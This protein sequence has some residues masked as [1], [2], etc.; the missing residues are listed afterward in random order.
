ML[1]SPM[2]DLNRAIVEMLRHDGRM[3]FINIAKRLEV[4]EGTVR[5]RVSWMKRAG[6]LRI[7]AI[8]DPMAVNYKADAMLGIKVGPK[9]TPRKVAER[10]ALNSQVVYALWVSG[11]FDLLIEI[12]CDD[13]EG[14]NRFL[15]NQV[16]GAGDIA[17][18]EVMGGLQMFKNQFLLKRD[19]PL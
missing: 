15:E 9:T 1:A 5:N 14:L 6:M 2:D 19:L 4:S 3:P 16:Y 17:S 13:E 10:L 12:V 8:A 18:V 7:V 11:R